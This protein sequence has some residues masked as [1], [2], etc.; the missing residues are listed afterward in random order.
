MTLKNSAFCSQQLMRLV[1]H[2]HAI[3]PLPKK[4][5]DVLR[6]GPGYGSAWYGS[7][8]EHWLKWLEEY[9]T[10]G[11]YGRKPAENTLAQVVY[12]RVIC[13]P[14]VFWLAETFRVDAT[15]LNAAH[16]AAVAASRSQASQSGAIRSVL[17][18]DVVFERIQVYEATH[19]NH[20]GP[21]QHSLVATGCNDRS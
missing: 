6:V 18:W 1:W 5:E 15:R 9:P 12:N 21:V 3:A 19:K 8:R 2:Q 17:T 13:P 7:Q 14:M 11:P 20:V 16:M 4:L 10:P